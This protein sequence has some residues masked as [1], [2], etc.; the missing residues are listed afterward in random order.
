MLNMSQ[1]CHYSKDN[2]NQLDAS[3]G[4]FIS[5]ISAIISGAANVSF[6]VN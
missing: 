3:E 1:Y 2:E 5:F 6:E 4:R